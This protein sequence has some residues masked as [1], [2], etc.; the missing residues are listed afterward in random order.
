MFRRRKKYDRNALTFTAGM[1][2]Q[3]KIETRCM[4]VLSLALMHSHVHV[5][6]TSQESAVRHAEFFATIG[7]DLKIEIARLPVAGSHAEILAAYV[8]RVLVGPIDEF[9]ANFDRGL[10]AKG[11]IALVDGEPR[12]A[13]QPLLAAYDAVRIS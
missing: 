3:E 2:E 13:A 11:A 7:K 1:S 12:A 10:Y 9:I 6:T 5:M 8:H 4:A